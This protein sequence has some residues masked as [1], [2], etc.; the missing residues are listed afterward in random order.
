MLKDERRR[1]NRA[2]FRIMDDVGRS[3]ICKLACGRSANLL[4]ANLHTLVII[5]H[6]QFFNLTSQLSTTISSVN[7]QAVD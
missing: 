3:P 2:T 6:S 7:I 5:S 4:V 1:D